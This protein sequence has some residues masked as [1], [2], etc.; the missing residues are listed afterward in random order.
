L[1][2]DSL[3]LAPIDLQI[4]DNGALT[5]ARVVPLPNRVLQCWRV[6]YLLLQ[7]ADDA[8]A[9]FWDSLYGFC[10]LRVCR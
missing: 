6:R 2:D 8:D 10:F 4:T 9:D 1:L 3:D 5:M 7:R